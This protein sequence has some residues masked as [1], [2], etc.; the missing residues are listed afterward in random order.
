L[1]LP[2]NIDDE[3]KKGCYRRLAITLNFQSSRILYL[4]EIGAG[5]NHSERLYLEAKHNSS[6]QTCSVKLLANGWR[7]VRLAVLS[8]YQG[9]LDPEGRQRAR[10]LLK[11]FYFK[12]PVSALE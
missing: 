9:F 5:S 12:R 7:G 4:F 1:Y 2:T 11:H 10:F 6:Q 8:G 3:G